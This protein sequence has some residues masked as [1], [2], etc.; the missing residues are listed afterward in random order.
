M[1]EQDEIKEESKSMVP[2][3][4]NVKL[5]HQFAGSKDLQKITARIQ[6]DIDELKGIVKSVKEQRQR[7]IQLRLDIIERLIYVRENK[8]ILLGERNFT[9]YLEKDIGITRGYFSEQVKAYELCLENDKPDY[10]KSIDT[11]VLV[12][13]ARIKNKELQKELFEKAPELTREDVRNVRRSNILGKPIISLEGTHVVTDFLENRK[14]KLSEQ[15]GS[16]MYQKI[17][18]CG[19]QIENLF[20]IAGSVEQCETLKETFQMMID[21]KHSGTLKKLKPEEKGNQ[22]DEQFD[23]GN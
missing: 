8:K 9:D 10:F 16:D 18:K 19:K 15:I 17:Y 2:A 21:T 1:S 4:S 7:A 6:V 13:I 14:N 22:Q 3:N 20:N 5:E 23:N 12:G 11:K